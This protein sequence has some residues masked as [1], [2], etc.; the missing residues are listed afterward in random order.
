[1][2]EYAVSDPRMVMVRAPKGR[3]CVEHIVP[4]PRGPSQSLSWSLGEWTKS[5]MLRG[6]SD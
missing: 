5:A 3:C 1:M 2:S 4:T 6:E